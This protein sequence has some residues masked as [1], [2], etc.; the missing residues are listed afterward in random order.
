V[1]KQQLNKLNVKN[2][3]AMLIQHSGVIFLSAEILVQNL[4]GACMA[5]ASL[6]VCSKLKSSK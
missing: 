4:I 2:D 5:T 3:I 1:G 6:F